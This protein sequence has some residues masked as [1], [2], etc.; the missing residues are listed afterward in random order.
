MAWYNDDNP[1]TLNF[2]LTGNHHSGYGLLQASLNAHPR[3]VCHGDVLHPNESVRK[4]EHES[5]FNYGGKFSDYFVPQHLSVEQYL[6]NKIFDNTLNEEKAVGVK[7]NYDTFRDYDLWDYID[8]RSRRGDF[9][10][11]HVTR[12]PVACFVAKQQALGLDVPFVGSAVY[13]DAKALT[14]F[15]RNHS[16]VSMKLDRYCPDRAIIPYHELLLDFR[17]VLERLFEFLELDFSPACIPNHRKVQRREIRYRVANWTD[18]QEKV[19]ADVRE[20][21]NDPFLY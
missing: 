1:E 12:N 8:Q 15:C 6:N 11:V 9:C 19:P 13:V 21:V 10:V 3:M 20:F 14:D 5:Y 2:V 4:T 18:L 16:A 7:I 17:G